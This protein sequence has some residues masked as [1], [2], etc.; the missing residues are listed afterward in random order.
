MWYSWIYSILR[1]K[2]LISRHSIFLWLGLFAFSWTRW[3]ANF[4]KTPPA[5]HPNKPHFKARALRRISVTYFG[6]E[7]C[8]VIVLLLGAHPLPWLLCGEAPA[9]LAPKAM[10][11]FFPL[12]VLCPYAWFRINEIVIAFYGDGLDSAKSERGFADL[13]KW[14]RLRMA[15]RSYFGLLFNFAILFCFLPWNYVTDTKLPKNFLEALYFSGV[16][17]ATLGYGDFYPTSPLARLLS[18]YE[19]VA[20]VLLVVLAIGSYIGMPKQEANSK[21]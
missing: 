12:M 10:P 9:W 15:I 18:V 20:G 6:I 14:E 17:I 8:A 1:L 4:L 3:I 7:I 5:T 11:A 2:R 13:K 21:N 19:V 16:T